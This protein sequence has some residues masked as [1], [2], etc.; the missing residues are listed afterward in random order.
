MARRG[1]R[2]RRGTRETARVKRQIVIFRVCSLFLFPFYLIKC[3]DFFLFLFLFEKKTV[4]MY[5]YK[6]IY[7]LFLTQKFFSL[8]KKKNKLFF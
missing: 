3:A 2:K 5:G 8:K 1:R 7:G 6:Q 4:V